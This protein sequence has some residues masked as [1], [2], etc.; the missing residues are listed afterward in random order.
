MG[1]SSACEASRKSHPASRTVVADPA[2]RLDRPDMTEYEDTLRSLAI[3]DQRFVRSVLRMTPHTV[4]VS[5]LD[6]KT[7]ALVRLGALLALDAAFSSYQEDVEAALAAGATADEIV[8]TLVAVAPSVG[9][10][11]VVSAASEL[12]LALGYDVEAALEAQPDKVGE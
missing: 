8:G 6:C 1:V 12:A 10:A 3:N 7:H 11:R 5:R 2:R 4:D 9:L